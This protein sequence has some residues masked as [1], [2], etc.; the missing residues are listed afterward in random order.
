MGCTYW[1]NEPPLGAAAV[2]TE[3]SPRTVRV[4]MPDGSQ[5]QLRE[6]R[7][8]QDTLTGLRENGD[9]MRVALAQVMQLERRAT[10]HYRT[11]LVGAAI[12]AMMVAAASFD[13]D[14]GDSWTW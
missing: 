11:A 9:T 4:T 14:L 13:W 10:D 8:A 1:R 5:V 7:I 6:A 2:V 12:F 3:T